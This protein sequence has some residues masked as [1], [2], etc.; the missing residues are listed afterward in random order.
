MRVWNV[1]EQ[2][3][4]GCLKPNTSV[5]LNVL[6]QFKD[7]MLMD[8][9]RAKEVSATWWANQEVLLVP[10]LPTFPAPTCQTY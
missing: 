4:G 8:G 10:N 7:K 6:Q 9:G 1:L 2:V 5:I 3:G